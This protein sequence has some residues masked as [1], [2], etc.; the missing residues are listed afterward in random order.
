M[1]SGIKQAFASKLTDVDTVQRDQLGTLRFEGNKVYKYVKL[2]N[3]TAT[4]AGVAGDT[5]AYDNED[6][7]NNN[8]VVT[9]RS[10]AGSV[11]VGAGM[12]L[13]AAAGTLAVATFLWIQIKG[14]ATLN[15]TIGG[16]AAD[17]DPLKAG[18]TDLAFTKQLFAGTTPNI[19]AD[20]PRV[21][22]AVDASA[23]FVALDCP[24]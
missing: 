13:A 9:D 2:Q 1:P 3:T 7:L 21:A 12:L 19:A 14:P 16:S 6:G 5:V 24:F 10:D 23:K 18:T 17:G 20:G 11:P 22:I 15:T 4:V 8:H